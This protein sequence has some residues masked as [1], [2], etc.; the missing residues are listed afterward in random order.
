MLII[1]A[2]VVCGTFNAY[3]TIY[4]IF[5]YLYIFLYFLY[6]LYLYSFRVLPIHKCQSVINEQVATKI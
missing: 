1:T 4:I 5:I 3:I 2:C 6:I